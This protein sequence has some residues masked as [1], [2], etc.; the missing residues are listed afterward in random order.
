VTIHVPAVEAD[1]EPVVIEQPV[2]VPFETVYDTA[3]PPVPPET[4]RL[5]GVPT[6]PE[7]EVRVRA[8]CGVVN[9]VHLA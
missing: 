1:S 6:V 8:A 5:R 9:S 4:V 7:V 3:P 2:A